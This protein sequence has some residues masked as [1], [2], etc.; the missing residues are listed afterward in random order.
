MNAE[1]Q[2]KESVRTRMVWFILSGWPDH[3]LNRWQRKS[4]S[5][6]TIAMVIGGESHFSYFLFIETSAGMA[7]ALGTRKVK[8]GKNN[9][10]NWS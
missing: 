10:D 4:E 7:Q 5:N 2:I 6:K 1:K 9:F 3:R 8:K